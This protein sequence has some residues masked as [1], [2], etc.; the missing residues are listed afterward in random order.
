MFPKKATYDHLSLLTLIGVNIDKYHHRLDG[1]YMLKKMYFKLS[2]IL[3]VPIIIVLSFFSIVHFKTPW[4]SFFLYLFGICLISYFIVAIPVYHSL[5]KP[6]TLKELDVFSDVDHHLTELANQ[7]YFSK[8]AK[9]KRLL[10]QEFELVTLRV[11]KSHHLDMILENDKL[12]AVPIKCIDKNTHETVKSTMIFYESKPLKPIVLATINFLDH[13]KKF[14][15]QITVPIE[16]ELVRGLVSEQI[17]YFDKSKYLVNPM[18]Y[19]DANHFQDI[20]QSDN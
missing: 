8:D 19:I 4:W 7:A 3:I 10:N 6:C 12:T 20:F 13:Q 9:A 5:I 15:R 1:I 16:F 2:L 17:T 18:I 14:N 11:V